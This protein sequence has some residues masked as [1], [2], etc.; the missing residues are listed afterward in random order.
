[1]DY[2]VK[3]EQ[4]VATNEQITVIR[5]SSS[6]IPH[7]E[8]SSVGLQYSGSRLLSLFALFGYPGR[9]FFRMLFAPLFQCALLFTPAG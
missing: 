8:R 4:T 2:G 1:M 5:N 6:S 3:E 7:R 9:L